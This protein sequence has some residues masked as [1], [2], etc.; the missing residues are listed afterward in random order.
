MFIFANK[1]KQTQL[2]IAMLAL[3]SMVI[4]IVVDVLMRYFLNSPVHG[5]YDL[6]ETMLVIVVF[7]S[8][9]SRFINR[10]NIVIDLIDN[11]IPTI[12]R[13]ALIRASDLINVA[14]LGLI[15]WSMITPALQAYDYG[16]KKLEL[17][18]KLWILWSIAILSVSGTLVCAVS[19]LFKPLPH[20]P[21]IG[22]AE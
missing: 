19:V 11:A 6:V 4:T 10:Q 5:A 21:A 1:I 3:A 16:D 14:L 7:N 9:S 22:E 2:Y 15:L 12:A 18:L 13:N 17:G 20:N 8:F